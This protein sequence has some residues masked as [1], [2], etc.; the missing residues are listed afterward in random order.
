MKSHKQLSLINF[1]I[2]KIEITPFVCDVYFCKRKI[3]K[4]NILHSDLLGIR[5][6]EARNCRLDCEVES[7]RFV[8]LLELQT[9]PLSDH[10]RI[11]DFERASGNS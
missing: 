1:A 7:R 5:A 4:F 10:R 2:N 11:I 3:L 6:K 9:L 8:V